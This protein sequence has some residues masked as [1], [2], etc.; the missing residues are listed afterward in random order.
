MSVG[1]LCNNSGRGGEER[2]TKP[3][4]II[5]AEPPEFSQAY[6]K[7]HR[8]YGFFSALLLGWELVGI[9]VST[10]PLQNVN[11]VL[12]S[13]QAL[14]WVLIALVI[15]F[16][17]RYLVEWMQ[18]SEQRRKRFISRLD[19]FVA[20]GIAGLAV[21]L[22]FYQTIS[23]VQLADNQ[24]VMA[25][26]FG[27]FQGCVAALMA[28][29]GYMLRHNDKMYKNLIPIVATLGVIILVGFTLGRF[30]LIGALIGIGV[31]L[32]LAYYFLKRYYVSKNIGYTP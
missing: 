7:A 17:F 9:D 14:P 31:G 22:Y 15:Y 23:K 28:V 29:N 19:F 4:S 5:L 21:A 10:A 25:L 1:K 27:W 3:E 8:H 16:G 30:L 24:R 13:P 6:H 20:H 32:P 12:K 18:S 26:V 2:R 11:I